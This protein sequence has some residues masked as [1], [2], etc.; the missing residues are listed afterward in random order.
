[1]SDLSFPVT[2]ESLPV[3]VHQDTRVI[4]TNLL[5]QLYGTDDKN[6]QMNFANNADRFENGKHFFKLEGEELRAFKHRP[7]LIGSVK[8]AR[9]VN[10]LLL[11]TERGAARHAKMLDT[12]QAWEVFGKLEDAYF[13][14]TEKPT[15]I[16]PEPP[17]L[18]YA[19]LEQRAPLVNAVRRLVKVAESKGRTLSYSDAHSIVNL[20]LGVEDIEHL[21]PEQIPQAMKLVGEILQ[22]IVLEGEYIPRGEPEPIQSTPEYLT[23]QQEQTL[24]HCAYLVSHQMPAPRSVAH[25]YW[26]RLRKVTGVPSPGKF[27]VRHLPLLAQEVR[28]FY[29][30][31]EAY[32]EVEYQAT[33]TI[34]KRLL[35]TENEAAPLLAEIAR[36]FEQASKETDAALQAKIQPWMMSQ[37]GQLA[38]PRLEG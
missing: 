29:A 25:A 26:Y 5:A 30:V 32:R 4:T 34:T 38:T 22:T 16:N 10:A 12:D 21:S 13:H 37:I 17:R 20:K 36:E 6:I 33:K 23:P 7:N 24:S 9:N 27:E 35:R 28:R 14:P 19:T 11:W 8:I 3:L 1:M 2:V 18:T 15:P 31:I